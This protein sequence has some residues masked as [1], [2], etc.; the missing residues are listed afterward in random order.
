MKSV[1]NWAQSLF[2]RIF[3]T[4]LLRRIVK[5]SSYLVSATGV[6][7]VLGFIQTGYILRLIGVAEFGLLGSIRTFSNIVNRF[8]SFRI[9]ELVVRN[10]RQ[11]EEQG[12][13]DKAAAVYK[14]AGLLEI[15]GASLAFVLIWLLAPWGARFFGRDEA[16]ASLWVLYGVVVLVNML[17]ESSTGL[18]Q[19]F[20]RFRPMAAITATQSAVTLT[21]VVIVSANNGGLY[22]IIWVYVVGKI[23]GAIGVVGYGYAAAK[24]EW[25]AGWWRTPLGVL[26]DHRRGLLR[27]AYSTNVSSTISIIAKDSEMLWVAGILGTTAAGYYGVALFFINIMKL[28]I[29]PLPK[30]TY[31]ELSREIALKKWST[32]RDILKRGTVLAMAYSLP[33]AIFLIVIGRPL[34]EFWS[35]SDYLPS[36][37]ILV[38][39]LV[40]F[41]FDNIFFWNRVTL[42]ALNRP[43]YPTAVN[44]V[45]MLFK[46]IGIFLLVP[47]FGTLGFAA[48]LSGYYLFTV[49]L[50][51]LRVY[52]DLNQKLALEPV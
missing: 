41:T 29:N 27:F 42:L 2:E 37:P 36:Y 11:F 7:M 5:N 40:G 30:A 15:L 38:I 18:L 34:I 50:A 28:P 25:G 47:Q 39:L 4:E 45:G 24:E 51:A 35:G 20:N 12:E 17:Y 44:F 8:T 16:S 3:E 14:L 6:T 46:V 22:E 31:P 1:T 43:A 9:N 13:R 23:V 48:L 49:G 52:L 32:A 19:V 33:M 10:V 21:L 26:N